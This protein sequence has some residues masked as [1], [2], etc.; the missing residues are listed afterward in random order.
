MLLFIQDAMTTNVNMQYF[1]P[2]ITMGS[3]FQHDRLVLMVM[4]IQKIMV[5][6][7]KKVVYVCNAHSHASMIMMFLNKHSARN[8]TFTPLYISWENIVGEQETIDRIPDQSFKA[9]NWI[10]KHKRIWY[11]STQCVI[12]LKE[13]LKRNGI[14]LPSKEMNRFKTVHFRHGGYFSLSLCQSCLQWLHL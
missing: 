7:S 12:A 3:R 8:N 5:Q 11:L 4:A 10:S 2:H 14:E 13:I 1:I 6:T 9:H